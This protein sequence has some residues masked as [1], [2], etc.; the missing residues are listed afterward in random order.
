MA[1]KYVLN[2]SL[3]IRRPPTAFGLYL[4]SVKG[5]ARGYSGRRLTSKTAVWRMDLLRLKFNHLDGA[6][7]QE[8]RAAAANA[9]HCNQAQRAKVLNAS[10]TGSAVAEPALAN[11]LAVAKPS[12]SHEAAV[13]EQLPSR[14]VEVAELVPFGVPAVAAPPSVVRDLRVGRSALPAVAGQRINLADAVSGVQKQLVFRDFLGHGVFGTCWKVVD[15]STGEAFCAKAASV[16]SNAHL[17]LRDELFFMRRCNHPNVMKPIG[18][19][20]Q[21]TVPQIVVMPLMWCDLWKFSVAGTPQPV[22][23]GREGQSAVAVPFAAW[24][25]SALIQIVAGLSHLHGHTI[26]HL[27]MKPDNVLVQRQPHSPGYI[28][29]VTDLGNAQ[30]TND[31]RS[32]ALVEFCQPDSVNA[33]PYRPFDLFQRTGRVKV[34][35]RFDIWALGCLVYDIGQVAP[36]SRDPAGHPDRLMGSE[37]MGKDV[38]RMWRRFDSR[39]A[40]FAK[41]D[42]RTLIHRL[43]PR[44]RCETVQM[45]LPA[46][47]AALRAL[48]EKNQS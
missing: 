42:A 10:A 48:A 15:I 36:R 3:G 39:L 14:G 33:L 12:P 24:E 21:D 43:C 18:A 2:T 30:C 20:M 25:L 11:G 38:G 31:P 45:T 35:P 8:F 16:E 6:V 27:D 9:A 44:S 32:R 37:I 4:K 47:A 40:K 17:A 26:Y 19:I 1:P 5:A 7:Q 46:A 34:T 13:A 22:V 23:A 41:P 28:F 29:R